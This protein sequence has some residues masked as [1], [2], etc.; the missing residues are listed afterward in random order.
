VTLPRPA[1]L[2]HLPEPV[3]C[4]LRRAQAADRAARGPDRR[5]ALAFT[6]AVIGGVRARGYPVATIA[7]CL[8]VSEGSVRD[9]AT[10]GAWLAADRLRSAVG[11][12]SP[13]DR[14][15]RHELGPPDPTM[16]G[17]PAADVV[18]VLAASADLNDY[19]LDGDAR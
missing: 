4:L 19:R 11:A 7:G 10:R 14:V 15:V 13:A 8:G 16:A 18:R 5:P 9:R 3:G 17:Y 6:R 1:P 12:G 2:C